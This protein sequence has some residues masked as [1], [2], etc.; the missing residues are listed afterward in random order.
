MAV[1]MFVSP[2][3]RLLTV[4]LLALVMGTSSFGDVSEAPSSDQPPTQDSTAR[5]V[6]EQ[7]AALP[8]TLKTLHYKP[9]ALQLAV[10]IP[11]AESLLDRLVPFLQL[12]Y[13]ETNIMAE[14]DLFASDIAVQL[15]ISAE[16]GLPGV[17]T[18][19]GFDSQS[20]LSVFLDLADAAAALK[21]SDKQGL[22]GLLAH[23]P[24]V[25]ALLALPVTDAAKA[26]ASFKGLLGNLLTRLDHTQS[27][28]GGITLHNYPGYG[29][30]F[31]NDDVLAISNDLSMLRESAQRSGA[32][33]PLQYG[34]A[35]CPIQDIHELVMLV[36][37]ERLIPFIAPFLNF[38]DEHDLISQIIYKTLFERLNRLYPEDPAAEPTILSYNLAQDHMAVDWK[39][40][41]EKRNALFEYMGP[42][43]ALRWSS[44]FPVDTEA[45]LSIH[46]NTQSKTDF[47]EIFLDSI[48]ES[49]RVLPG[50][51]Q[52][53]TLGRSL[54]NLMSGEAALGIGGLSTYGL[55]SIFSAFELEDS[56]DAEIV[57]RIVPQSD[58]ETPYRG[59]QL[60]ILE[61]PFFIPIYFAY[62]DG[63][64]LMSNNDSI[65]HAFIDQVKDNQDHGYFNTFEPPLSADTASYQTIVV[66]SGLY[67]NLLIPLI[68][69]SRLKI[70]ESVNFP[71]TRGIELFNEF[72]CINEQRGNWSVGSIYLR[73][74]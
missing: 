42:P 68:A 45:F 32:P 36:Y 20:G 9:E 2:F 44:R 38:I 24:D 10:G 4:S 41:T 23:L 5:V 39:V 6:E 71:L 55:P 1:H 51:S 17:L 70:P 62:V 29:C 73:R 60:K 27:E 67:T 72:R 64:L 3:S 28:E 53:I 57:L 43:G 14:I 40:N 69:V 15:G 30:Y 34:C 8:L 33:A 49:V 35:G 25:K 74:N 46:V 61:I 16:G 66:R 21:T 48:P 13:E 19:M 18:T 31:V 50:V 52:G 22:I 54:L 37:C 59:V 56:E 11:G 58:Y 65:L 7:A 12:F 63:A 26:E 47:S